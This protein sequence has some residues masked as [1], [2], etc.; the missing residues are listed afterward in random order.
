MFYWQNNPQNLQLYKMFTTC[1]PSE[2]F[3]LASLYPALSSR[4]CVCVGVAEMRRRFT[5]L[6][7]ASDVSWLWCIISHTRLVALTKAES[8]TAVM[9]LF[10]R[11]KYLTWEGMVGIAVRPR[12]SQYMATG[13]V[14][15]QSHS[16]GHSTPVVT[17]CRELRW[18][19]SQAKGSR[20]WERESGS[21][22]DKRKTITRR[23][24]TVTKINSFI[25][26]REKKRHVLKFK[27]FTRLYLSSARIFLLDF[28]CFEFWF[29]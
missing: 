5:F 1:Q 20:P 23:M 22:A 9:A 14:G 4:V 28:C 3:R 27:S 16:E 6:P 26:E 12:P 10:W 13:K 21:R 17:A 15:G 25:W 24:V 7:M 2:P 19:Y 11:Y 8:G 29:C 18:P